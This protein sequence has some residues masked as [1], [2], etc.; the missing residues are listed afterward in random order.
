MNKDLEYIENFL[1]RSLKKHK[2]VFKEG[3]NASGNYEVHGTIEAMQGKQKVDGYYFSTVVPKP[4]DVR[5]Y[6]FPM[7]THREK[8]F[9]G[10]SVE[11]AKFLKGKS[12]YHIKFLNDV[13]EVEI[14]KLIATAVRIYQEDGLLAKS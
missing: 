11:L 5:L 4:K 7:Y 2:S 10:M 6:F 14:D 12:C 13:L 8:L 9:D 1:I 3:T